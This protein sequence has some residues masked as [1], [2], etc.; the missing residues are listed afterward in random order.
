MIDADR[1]REQQLR[2]T[3]EHT[4]SIDADCEPRWLARGVLFLL[5]QIAAER[6]ARE[7]LEQALQKLCQ[8][9]LVNA[10]KA[11]EDGD[12]CCAFTQEHDVA[13]VR[14]LLRGAGEPR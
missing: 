6:Q 7:R 4:E 10:K 14:A 3:V 5:D 8:S 13:D 12:L 2:E 11:D 9:W 1:A